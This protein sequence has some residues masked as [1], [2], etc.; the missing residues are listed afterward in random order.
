MSKPGPTPHRPIR[1][2]VRREGR[3]TPGQQRALETL[4]PRYGIDFSEEPLDLA[5]IFGRSA[6]VTLEIGFGNGESLAQMAEAAPERDFLGIEVHRPGVGR[7][8]ARIE[9]LGLTN[10][11]VMCHDAVEVLEHRIAPGCLDTVQIFFPDPWHKKRHHKRRLI[12]PAFVALLATRL[13]SGGTLHLATDWEDY[14]RHMLDVLN[15]SPEFRNTAD[16]FA[17]RPP[18]RPLTKFEQRGQTRGH[19]VWDLIFMKVEG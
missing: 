19:G 14:A 3:L 9:A 6:P 18:H 12:Q 13:R 8:L 1:S 11:R 10:L 2:F 5:A 4:W 15:A 16:G 7:L 17:P